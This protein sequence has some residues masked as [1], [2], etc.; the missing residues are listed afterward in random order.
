MLTFQRSGFHS[1]HLRHYFLFL[2]IFFNFPFLSLQDQFFTDTFH[3]TTYSHLNLI[4]ILIGITFYSE[5]KILRQI[6]FRNLF[7]SN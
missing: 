5:E 2:F 7:F 4:D 6:I 1:Q 3:L